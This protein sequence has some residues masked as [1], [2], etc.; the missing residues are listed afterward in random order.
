M[1]YISDPQRAVISKSRFREPIE[2][3]IANSDFATTHFWHET[4]FI[5]LLETGL[6]DSPPYEFRQ[7]MICSNCFGTTAFVSGLE[8]LFQSHP[9]NLFP[10]RR[11]SPGYICPDSM[12][13]FLTSD[14]V[15]EISSP[16]P[17]CIVAMGKKTL[18][19]D[20]FRVFF[21]LFHTAVYLSEGQVFEQMGSC[22]PF[23][24][25]TLRDSSNC[26]FFRIKTFK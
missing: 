2:Y 26:R 1:V 19:G 23:S 5:E 24:V 3:L 15:E 22:Y 12:H 18:Q 7:Q 14:Y 20:L 4:G 17:D 6:V 8:G 11:R 21:D 9:N 16:K 25:Y 10:S 13:S